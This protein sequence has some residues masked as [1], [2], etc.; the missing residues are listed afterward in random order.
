M[1]KNCYRKWIIASRSH[2]FVW[3]IELG[4][5][6]SSAQTKMRALLFSLGFGL[7][8]IITNWKIYSRIN[9]F[10]SAFV[11]FH[12]MCHSKQV[13]KSRPINGNHLTHTLHMEN[14]HSFACVRSF[15]LQ[16]F[17]TTNEQFFCIMWTYIFF[18]FVNEN[19]A[20]DAL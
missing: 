9:W 3:T 7:F 17:D 16:Y 2:C 13:N 15:A 11:W 18:S 8:L 12:F 1:R 6:N 19:R 4:K 20:R 14:I 5:M 10:T